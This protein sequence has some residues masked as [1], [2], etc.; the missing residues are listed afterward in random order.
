VFVAIKVSFLKPQMNADERRCSDAKVKDFSPEP[1]GL[2]QI[3]TFSR[4]AKKNEV[5]YD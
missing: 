2:S 1:S 5:W 4:V 3:F